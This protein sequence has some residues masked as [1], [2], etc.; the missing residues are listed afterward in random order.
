MQQILEPDGVGPQGGRCPSEA[1]LGSGQGHLG[2]EPV[3]TCG[4]FDET[5]VLNL[6]GGRR[7]E[8]GCEE[9]GR[10]ETWMEKWRGR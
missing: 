2:I 4:L 3:L 5:I 8:R 1:W 6:G 10:R 7:E 9:E